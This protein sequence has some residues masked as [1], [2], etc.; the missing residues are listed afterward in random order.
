[1]TT[2]DKIAAD[3]IAVYF[4]GVMKS[5]LELRAAIKML[6]NTNLFESNLNIELIARYNEATQGINMFAA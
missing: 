4:Y 1:M 6:D 2:N 5:G 3:M